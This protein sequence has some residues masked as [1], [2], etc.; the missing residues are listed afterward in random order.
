MQACEKAALE[1]HRGTDE[2]LRIEARTFNR[3]FYDP[4]TQEGLRQFTERDRPDRLRDQAARTPGLV[5][6]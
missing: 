1:T 4:A 6:D 3:S 5:R 2:G